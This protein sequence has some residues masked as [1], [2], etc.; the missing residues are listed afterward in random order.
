[1]SVSDSI[2]CAAIVRYRLCVG[3]NGDKDLT[4][5][6]EPHLMRNAEAGTAITLHHN[7]QGIS[8]S[9]SKTKDTQ[10]NGSLPSVKAIGV[11]E[12]KVSNRMSIADEVMEHLVNNRVLIDTQEI[13]TTSNHL[14]NALTNTPFKGHAEAQKMLDKINT[15]PNWF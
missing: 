9:T 8:I 3:S 4:L 1:M 14:I 7:K 2:H 13:S 11:I 6:F 5:L 10:L 12:I 15:D